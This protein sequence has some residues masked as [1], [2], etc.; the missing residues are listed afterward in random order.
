MANDPSLDELNPD[1]NL[2]DN[3]ISDTSDQSI[4]DQLGSYSLDDEP[5]PSPDLP[6]EDQL[7]DDDNS[8]DDDGHP[9][10]GDGNAPDPSSQLPPPSQGGGANSEYIKRYLAER[11]AREQ[12]LAKREEAVR[13]QAQAIYAERLRQKHYAEFAK[14]QEEKQRAE[15]QRNLP[16]AEKDPARYQYYLTLC[17]FMPPQ[18]ALALV[19]EQD[20]YYEAQFEKRFGKAMEKFAPYFERQAEEA[21]VT[22]LGNLA[23]SHI[24]NFHNA[25]SQFDVGITPEES[26]AV[27]MAYLKSYIDA[28]HRDLRD[29]DRWFSANSA[30]ILAA[31]VREK[32]RI[33][34]EDQQR[35]NAKKPPTPSST[36]IPSTKLA[37]QKLVSTGDEARMKSDGAITGGAS[38]GGNNASAGLIKSLM[39]QTGINGFT[40]N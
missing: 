12:A 15:Q 30:N 28:G 16:P 1:V 38:S 19:N 34:A 8:D 11:Q 10:D 17:R 36:V 25:A 35:N 14:A 6:V 27:V 3:S 32:R 29:I 31:T 21:Y 24:S 4:D 23:Y 39:E 2:D 33:L 37:N 7:D 26:K 22:D 13:R 18:Q 20:T 40:A 9:D 5:S